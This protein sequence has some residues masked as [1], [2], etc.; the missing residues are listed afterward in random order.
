[1]NDEDYM[2]IALKEAQK[3]LAVDE[4]P[5][6]AV[7]V[8]PASGKVVAKASNK[9][10]HGRDPSAHAEILAIR[11]A[12]RKLGDKRLWGLD[13]YVTLEPCTMCAAAASLA[14]LRRIVFAAEDSKGGAVING[15]RFYQADTC[16][17]RPEVV[18]GILAEPCSRVLKDFFAKKRRESKKSLRDSTFG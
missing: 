13:L 16:H 2:N 3:A 8:D 15:V 10:E 18:G 11:K 12:A 7:I 1:M 6:G 17:H 14:R 4:V 5:V 9:T